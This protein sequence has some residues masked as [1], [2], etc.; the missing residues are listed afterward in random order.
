[1][2]D[3]K[4]TPQEEVQSQQER[5]DLRTRIQNLEWSLAQ[6]TRENKILKSQ[7]EE[8]LQEVATL[9]AENNELRGNADSNDESQSG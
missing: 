4:K 7:V 3:Q 5:Q 6:K 9:T 1:M 2:S 8:R